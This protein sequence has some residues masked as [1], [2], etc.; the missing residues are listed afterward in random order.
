MISVVSFQGVVCPCHPRIVKASVD[1]QR[2]HVFMPRTELPL[3]LFQTS[4]LNLIREE[5]GVGKHS[6]QNQFPIMK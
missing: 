4:G 5:T 6:H 2:R 1:E 3:R